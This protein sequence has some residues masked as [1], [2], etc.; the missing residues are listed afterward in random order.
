MLSSRSVGVHGCAQPLLR[1]RQVAG[2]CDLSQVSRK[3]PLNSG[4]ASGRGNVSGFNGLS[5]L[6]DFTHLS[7]RPDGDPDSS[8]DA[9][10]HVARVALRAFALVRYQCPRFAPGRWPGILIEVV[11]QRFPA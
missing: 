9:K 11:T 7:A 1:G 6:T 4:N 8:Q 2:W 10:G 5:V 3:T